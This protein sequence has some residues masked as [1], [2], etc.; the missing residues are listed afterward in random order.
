MAWQIRPT[1]ILIHK[2]V[3][4]YELSVN[5][6]LLT[7]DYYDYLW[8]AKIPLV[9]SL[10]LTFPWSRHLWGSNRGTAGKGAWSGVETLDGLGSGVAT[11]FQLG[12]MAPPRAWCLKSRVSA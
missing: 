12:Y 7:Y 2:E 10:C 3:F 11:G 4:P 5:T 1:P 9:R 6:T 8:L